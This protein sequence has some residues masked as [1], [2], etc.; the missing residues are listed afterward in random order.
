MKERKTESVF[1]SHPLAFWLQDCALG[2][3]PLIPEQEW[4]MEH[5]LNCPKIH[6]EEI[7]NGFLMTSL[8]KFIDPQTQ[9]SLDFSENGKSKK[10]RSLQFQNLLI[11]ISRFY[12]TNLEQIIVCQLP[13]LHTLT[14]IEFDG[15]DF[16]F[17][18]FELSYLDSHER[19]QKVIN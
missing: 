2:D 12:E 9:L 13:D 6:F 17:V 11:R 19:Y 7:S 5:R 10:G 3:P 4:R 16:F 15:E 1:W 14:R 18:K 8:M